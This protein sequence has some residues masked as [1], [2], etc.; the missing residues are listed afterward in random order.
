MNQP[1][2]MR[3]YHFLFSLGVILLDQLSKWAV[4]QR[5][6]LHESVAVIPGFFRLTHVQ[7]LGA[8]FGLFADSQSQ[9]RAGALIAFS[10]VA[11]TIVSTL[12]W[13]NSH[14]FTVTG[15]ALA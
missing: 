2:A 4:G 10:V 6:E 12:L 1:H 5:I 11:M 13:R 9:F 7:N 15:T 8:A 14:Q 3:R